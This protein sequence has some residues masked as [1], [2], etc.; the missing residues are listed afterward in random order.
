MASGSNSSSSSE[1][2]KINKP[3]ELLP[4][5]GASTC[6]KVLDY[7]GFPGKDGNNLTLCLIVANSVKLEKTNNK[8]QMI[9]VY[10]HKL[11]LSL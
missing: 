3:P 8:V 5:I 10:K 6:S 11:Y 4:P 1:V 7:F 9:I 2:I